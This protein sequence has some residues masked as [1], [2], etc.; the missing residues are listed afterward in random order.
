M[1]RIYLL[2]S[3]VNTN[4]GD[5]NVHFVRCIFDTCTVSGYSINNCYNASAYIE[6]NGC[7]V[8]GTCS[9]PM[10]DIE[11]SS[12]VTVRG[13]DL[14]TDGTASGVILINECEVLMETSLKEISLPTLFL[15]V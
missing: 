9:A 1:A 14:R 3:Q 2:Q 7:Y 8:E 12:G 6:L 13:C 15:A 5:D 10:I 4:F 11:N